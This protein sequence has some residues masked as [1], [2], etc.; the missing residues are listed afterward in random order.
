MPRWLVNSLIVLGFLA[1]VG[2]A[3]LPRTVT[4]TVQI[5][6][7]SSHQHEP[8]DTGVGASSADRDD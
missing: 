3:F 4:V 1:L 7:S 2:L 6:D 8:R 5:E